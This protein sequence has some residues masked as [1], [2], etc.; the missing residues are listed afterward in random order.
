MKFKKGGQSV[1][2]DLHEGHPVKF[3]ADGGFTILMTAETQFQN[4]G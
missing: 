4:E 3:L 2:Y 1:Q